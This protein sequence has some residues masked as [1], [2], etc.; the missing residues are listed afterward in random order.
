MTR[1]S[2]SAALAG[3]IALPS[4]ADDRSQ[5]VILTAIVGACLPAR[6][7]IRTPADGS[8]AVEKMRESVWELRTYSAASPALAV[9]FGHVFPRAGIR[10]WLQGLA[11][12]DLTYLI[13]FDDLTTRDRAWTTLNADP[14]W[15]SA[16]PEFPSY[17]FGLYRFV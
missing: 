15:I 1:R 3:A 2:F 16:R 11:G 6:L 17:R 8:G 12:T 4:F 9:L 7:E 5:V 10:P 14:C 13:P